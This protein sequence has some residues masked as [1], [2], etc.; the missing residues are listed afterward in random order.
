VTGHDVVNAVLT[1]SIRH[2]TQFALFGSSLQPEVRSLYLPT[3]L[4][5][6]SPVEFPLSGSEPPGSDQVAP[7]TP[8]AALAETLY[9]PMVNQGGEP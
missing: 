5:V 1:V 8:A 7:G 9:L 2:L 3:I 6:G 4:W